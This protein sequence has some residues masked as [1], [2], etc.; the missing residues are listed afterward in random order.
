M[1]HPPGKTTSSH[2]ILA[3]PNYG[4]QV[5]Q[6]RKSNRVSCCQTKNSLCA[7]FLSIFIG[8]IRWKHFKKMFVIGIIC[9]IRFLNTWPALSFFHLDLDSFKSIFYK[10]IRTTKKECSLFQVKKVHLKCQESICIVL[11][12][13]PQNAWHFDDSIDKTAAS[14]SGHFRFMAHKFRRLAGLIPQ[15]HCN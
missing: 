10:E 13:A 6:K 9:Y 1:K 4:V 8:T 3:V 11:L 12:N 15:L 14:R 5:G 7:N 2:S